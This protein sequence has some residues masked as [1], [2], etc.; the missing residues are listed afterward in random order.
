MV[1]IGKEQKGEMIN[2]KENMNNLME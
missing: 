2:S 1:R